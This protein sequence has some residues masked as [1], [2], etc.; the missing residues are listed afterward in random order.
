MMHL[1]TS[2]QQLI[3]LVTQDSKTAAPAVEVDMS[4]Y[5]YATKEDVLLKVGD[6]FVGEKEVIDRLASLLYLLAEAKTAFKELLASVKCHSEWT[7]EHALKLIVNDPRYGALKSLG[8]KKQ[9]FNEYIIQRRNEEKEEERK[10]IKQA[11]ED[12]LQLIM[13]STEVKLTHSYRRA[14]EIFEDEPRWKAEAKT[15]FKELLASVKCHSEW[16][17]EHALKLIVNDPR[18]GALKSLGEKKQCFNEYIIQ[19]RNEEKEEERKRIKQARED[20]L[21]LIMDSTE[22][23]LTHSYRRAKEIFEDEPRWKAVPEREREELFHEGQKEKDRREKEE[24]K[25]DKKRKAQAF[26]ELLESISTIQ[27][28][29]EWRK[30]A[31]KLE[32][33]EVFEALDKVD[34]LEVY[35]EYMKELERKEREEKEREREIKR[36]QDRIARDNFKALLLKHRS[37]GLINV[38]TRWREYS[39]HVVDEEEY[40]AVEQCSPGS[41]RPKELF[42]YLIE[43]IEKEYEAAKLG[44]EEG[45]P[46]FE[47]HIVKLKKKA[48]KR[49]EEEEAAG[50]D[51]DGKR[52]RDSDDDSHRK[53]KKKSSRKH[54]RSD[55]EDDEDRK[56]RKKKHKEKKDRRDKD[57]DRDRSRSRAPEDAD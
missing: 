50:S 29:T 17:W 4:K 16:T 41:S 25:A 46:I 18:Y 48:E 49:R 12:F 32:G 47:E 55:D 33:E 38:K 51:D 2:S 15:A 23:K 22:V 31:K 24:K 39:K 42:E 34:R 20:F 57:K 9:C 30:V 13:D 52:R 3:L 56:S 19:R 44:G 27:F 21:Q 5:Q 14:K 8:E 40:K 26:R 36:R 35:Q 7:W 53:H 1:P 45:K 43:D 28:G 54:D 11:R 6:V 37:Q 10:R